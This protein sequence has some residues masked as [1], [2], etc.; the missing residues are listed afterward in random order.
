LF[1]REDREGAKKEASV[2]DTVLEPGSLIQ[3]RELPPEIEATSHT[4]IGAAIEVHRELGPGLLESIYEEALVHELRL[5]GVPVER[6]VEIVINYKGAELRGQRMDLVVN[7]CIIVE[8]KAVVKLQDVFSAQLL[9]YLR[10]ANLPLGLLL[11]FHVVLLKSGIER[12]FNERAP[13]VLRRLPASRP[14]RPS[15]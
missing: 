7:G 14:S 12:V 8:I 5:R 13:Q 6:Q 3:K 10:A 9:S 1:K 11:N 2:S 15:R 4:V